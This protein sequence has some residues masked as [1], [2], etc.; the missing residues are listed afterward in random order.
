MREL[1]YSA[2][3][4]AAGSIL[5]ACGG[6]GRTLPPQA[7]SAHAT[8]ASSTAPPDYHVGVDY[9][10]YGKD[11][12]TT[13]F[14]T[15][16][17]RPA[18]RK[19]VRAQLQGMA[20]RRA[21]V[22]STH[23]WFVHLPRQSNYGQTWQATFPMSDREQTNLRMYAKDVAAIRG[24][25]GNRLRLDLC[26]LWLGA[27]DYTIGTPKTGLG[28]DKLSASDFTHRVQVTADK[29]LAA[30]RDIKRPDGVQ[31]VDTVYLDTVQIAQTPNQGWFVA[32][33]YPRFVSKVKSSDFSPALYFVV[34][35]TQADV[36]RKGYV[37]PYYPI[38]DGHRSMV[39]MYSSLKFLADHR[40][41][42]PW[43]ID[44]AYYVPNSG[45]P[46]SRLDGPVLR[47]VLDDADATLPSLGARRAYG[48]AETFYFVRKAIREPFAR[49]FGEEAAAHNRLHRLT[50]WTTPDADRL[51]PHGHNAAYPF[52]IEEYL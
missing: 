7:L 40:L 32:K 10:A 47:R 19:A 18:V 2:V 48:I 3:F 23:I 27:A 25:S 6:G 14:I 41:Y 20:D 24:S 49:A 51:G 21:T 33:H 12:N 30:V 36:L 46:D 8:T 15:I 5:V 37:D 13:A 29:M 11:F 4:L 39:S 44:F 17:D 50:F 26:S 28:W 9:H 34:D 45:V 1:F 42:I 22:I 52:A 35:C 38:L 16:Y 43:R 31:L